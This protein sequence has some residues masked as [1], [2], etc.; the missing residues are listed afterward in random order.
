[1]FGSSVPQLIVSSIVGGLLALYGAVA[2]AASFTF[3]ASGELIG[4][5]GPADGEA[6]QIDNSEIRVRTSAGEITTEGL[7]PEAAHRDGA[8][9]ET[10]YKQGDFTLTVQ[11]TEGK[12]FAE[13]TWSLA[14]LRGEPFTVEDVAEQIRFAQDFARIDL[15]TDGSAYRVPINLFLRANDMSVA[16]GVA[17]PWVELKPLERRG[18]EVRYDVAI[19]IPAGQEFHSETFFVVAC[20]YVGAVCDKPGGETRILLLEESEPMDYGEVWA[21]QDYVAHFAPE[22]PLPED[23]YWVW[24]NGWWARSGGSWE[25]PQTVIDKLADWGIHDLLTPEV[26][27][28]YGEHPVNIPALSE[29]EPGEVPPIPEPTRKLIEYAQGRGMHVASFCQPAIWYYGRPEWK[30]VRKDGTPYMYIG[31]IGKPG[32]NCWAI[33]EFTRAF[34]DLQKEMLKAS[35]SR[36]WAWDGRMLSF[37]E[38]DGVA[39]G[40]PPEEQYSPLP[41]Y[42]EGHDHAPGRQFFPEYRKIRGMID[43]M[44]EAFPRACLQSYWGLKRGMPWIMRGLNAQENYYEISG[45]WDQALQNWYTQNYRFVPMYMNW[46][47][48]HEKDPE[49]FEVNLI[50]CLSS[51]VHAQMGASYGAIEDPTNKATFQKWTAFADRIRPFLSRGRWLFGQPGSTWVTGTAHCIDDRGSLFL[52]RLRDPENASARAE[53]PLNDLIGLTKGE[54][55]TVTEVHPREGRRLGVYNHGDSV[56]FAV[57]NPVEVYVVEATDEAVSAQQPEDKDEGTLTR[58]FAAGSVV[59]LLNGRENASR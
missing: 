27:W 18:A 47:N 15:H 31:D 7:Q 13:R 2:S 38:I 54:R 21:M 34:T 3:G 41:C 1:M 6:F 58:S 45:I 23:G 35:G 50:L 11:W 53:V 40:D 24:L 22:Q 37:S 43:E 8:T 12:G 4:V 52:F 42:G 44:R 56:R 14:H 59:D 28:G 57:E 39:P 32:Y 20:P 49:R 46:T 25:D 17:Y 19:D 30:S 26:W 9:V 55:F 29:L 48:L 36:F 10:V 51:S 33:D 16:V 5:S